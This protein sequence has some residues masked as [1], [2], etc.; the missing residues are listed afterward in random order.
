[1]TAKILLVQFFE[2][3]KGGGGGP[4]RSQSLP[5]PGLTLRTFSLKTFVFDTV[6]PE[7]NKTMT[8]NLKMAKFFV[9][10]HGS[11]FRTNI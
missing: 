7:K 1:M 9:P 8:E 10:M 3:G 2:H 6:L 11:D 5:R 4:P